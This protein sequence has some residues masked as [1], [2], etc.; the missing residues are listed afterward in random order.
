MKCSTVPSERLYHPVLHF[1]A[2]QKLMFSLCQTCV[3]ISNTGDCCHKTDEERGLTGTWVID[4]VRLT[5]EGVHDSGNLCI[6]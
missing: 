1:R 5:A 6:V 2:N 3:L 4:E